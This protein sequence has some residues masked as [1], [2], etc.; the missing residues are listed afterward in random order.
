MNGITIRLHTKH[1]RMSDSL[2]FFRILSLSIMHL[3]WKQLIVI[4]NG[5]L[6]EG[7]LE[8]RLPERLTMG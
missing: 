2:L 3:I 8:I 4:S 5:L 6:V 7:S 1:L